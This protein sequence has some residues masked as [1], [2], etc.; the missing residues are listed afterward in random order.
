MR[1]DRV[2]LIGELDQ[3]A[4]LRVRLLNR[5]LGIE[6]KA[7]GVLAQTHRRDDAE[8]LVLHHDV[9]ELRLQSALSE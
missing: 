6:Q 2:A 3:I 1:A 4:A 9:I 8:H 5:L 7:R